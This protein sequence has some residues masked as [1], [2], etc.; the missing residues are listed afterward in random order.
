MAASMEDQLL[1]LLADTQSAAQGPR[2]QA[3]SHLEQLQSNEAFPTSLATIASH[4][5]VSSAIRQSALSV[6]RRYVEH[7]WSGQDEDGPTI[8]IPEHVKA[9]LRDQL[10]GLATSNEDDRK[11]R[12]AARYVVCS[13]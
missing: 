7:N 1:Q 2:K 11:V 9:Q 6:L 8:T 12:S 3:E 4:S 13:I 5:S 10:L